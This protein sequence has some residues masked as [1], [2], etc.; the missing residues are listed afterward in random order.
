MAC[1]LLRYR[2]GSIRTLNFALFIVPLCFLVF[3]VRCAVKL[4]TQYPRSSPQQNSSPQ[5]WV[6]CPERSRLALL[7]QTRILCRLHWTSWPVLLLPWAL[8]WRS[9][10]QCMVVRSSMFLAMQ[11]YLYACW[12]GLVK[13]PTKIMPCIV[14]VQEGGG[15]NCLTKSQSAD[16]VS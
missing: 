13:A 16:E 1:S 6:T 9:T 11:R 15:N 10:C 14:C 3:I 7:I 8:L 12:L 2:T 5:H 4:W